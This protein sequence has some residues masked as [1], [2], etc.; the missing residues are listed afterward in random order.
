MA[1]VE[2][3]WGLIPA[4]DR[5][6]GQALPG[7]DELG[8]PGEIVLAGAVDCWWVP[9]FTGTTEQAGAHDCGVQAVGDEH[10]ARAACDQEDGAAGHGGL[11]HGDV[12]ALSL[13]ARFE[14]GAG[15]C[16]FERE[17]S[18]EPKADGVVLYH[19]Q[20][21]RRFGGAR[22][23]AAIDAVAGRWCAGRPWGQ[24]HA[25]VA[26]TESCIPSRALGR[27][28]EAILLVRPEAADA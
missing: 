17:A 3:W 13:V 19:V 8:G 16:G 25:W 20:H 6:P 24:S 28:P 22:Y 18:A 11:A 26:L 27:H 21:L 14:P 5:S 15:H 4:L 9:V 10:L 7:F 23:A 12:H 1:G 2:P